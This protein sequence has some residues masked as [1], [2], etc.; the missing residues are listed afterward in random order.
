MPNERKFALK[1]ILQLP[2]TDFESLHSLG[3]GFVSDER[4][5]DDFGAKS[6]GSRNRNF[7]LRLEGNFTRES[8]PS[9]I[10]LRQLISSWEIR[11]SGEIRKGTVST[12]FGRGLASNEHRI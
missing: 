2:R 4:P 10:S 1:R 3:D 11:L 6:A 8:I 5:D 7:D 9:R 12:R